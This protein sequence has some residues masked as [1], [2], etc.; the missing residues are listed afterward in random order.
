MAKFKNSPNGAKSFHAKDAKLWIDTAAKEDVPNA[1]LEHRSLV[2]KKGQTIAIDTNIK[3]TINGEAQVGIDFSFSGI[4][5]SATKEGILINR[6]V[7]GKLTRLGELKTDAKSVTIALTRDARVGKRVR[8][9]VVAGDKNASGTYSVAKESE[10]HPSQSLRQIASTE[11]DLQSL[12]SKP[13]TRQVEATAGQ[14]K[15]RQETSHES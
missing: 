2:V 1:I 3:K 12:G 9:L 6:R 7:R 11:H 5:V 14:G 15:R 4:V 10:N 13:S 8:W